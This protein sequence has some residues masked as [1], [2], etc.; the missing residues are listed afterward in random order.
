MNHMCLSVTHLY[1]F[2]EKHY[3][4]MIYSLSFTV[5]SC[6][7]DTLLL[8]TLTITNKSRIPVY[9]GLTE[10]DSPYY[11]FLLFGTQKDA[12]KVSTITR[13]DC[14]L[15]KSIM[16]GQSLFLVPQAELQFLKQPSFALVFTMYYLFNISLK[17]PSSVFASIA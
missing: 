6:L 3:C 11:R 4:K 10:N 5:N 9:R 12:P 13:V 8:W 14:I 1:Y 17:E 16:Q 7:A 2:I 15:E